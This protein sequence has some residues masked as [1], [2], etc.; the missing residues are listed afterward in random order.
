LQSKNF[1]LS[2]LSFKDYAKEFKGDFM[3]FDFDNNFK[4]GYHFATEGIKNINLKTKFPGRNNAQNS[5]GYDASSATGDLCDNG[6]P[7]DPDCVYTVH[8]TFEVICTGGWNPDEGFNPEYCT[9]EIVSVYCELEYC[10]GN[11]GDLEAC[12]NSGN[13][14]EACS[15]SL[16]GVGCGGEEEEGS[17]N[18]TQGEAIA[19]LNAVTGEELSNVSYINGSETLADA[20]GVIRLPRQP[21]WKFYRLNFGAGYNPHY[22][23]HFTGTVYK[24]SPND[25]WKWESVQYTLTDRDG[26]IPP[27]LSAP[28]Q[29]SVT[30]PIISSDKRKATTSVSYTITISISCAFGV[31]TQ[32]KTGSIPSQELLAD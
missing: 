30:A 3:M 25:L 14:P 13:T 26:P 11:T 23:A 8:T 5:S 21:K 1:N 10:N 22:V 32:I 12:I 7:I 31:E 4:K 17:C 29:A 2:N 20:N 19:A 15:C 28:I 24:N 18:M 9:L 16:Y 6:I 27:C